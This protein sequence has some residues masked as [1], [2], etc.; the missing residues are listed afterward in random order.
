MKGDIP[1]MGALADVV[2][3][4][5]KEQVTWRDD[6][7]RTHP[8]RIGLLRAADRQLADRPRLGGR[9]RFPANEGFITLQVKPATN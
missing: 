5:Y 4:H 2:T 7:D 1:K 9:M 6:R 3:G 8:R